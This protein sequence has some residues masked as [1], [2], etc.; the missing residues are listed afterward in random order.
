MSKS[1][2]QQR[3]TFRENA[4]HVGASFVA[5]ERLSTGRS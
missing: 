5:K 3:N 4:I 1:D 2:D